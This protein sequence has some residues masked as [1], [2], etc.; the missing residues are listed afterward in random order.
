MADG[1][2]HDQQLF[3][4]PVNI[5]LT[6]GFLLALAGCAAGSGYDEITLSDRRMNLRGLEAVSIQYLNEHPK[7]FHAFSRILTAAD[8]A[9]G[10]HETFSRGTV[11]RWI[12]Q[13]LTRAGYDETMP[14]YRFLITV[15]LEGWKGAY[16]TR[17]D[18]S[19]REFLFD[20]ISSVMGGMHLCTTCS[21]AQPSQP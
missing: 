4:H 6:V 17:V 16:L 15:Y 9:L 2:K 5:V 12:S 11:M 19:D 21:T 7:E 13:E 10:K 3:T 20:L 1:F 8:D 18:G 14:V